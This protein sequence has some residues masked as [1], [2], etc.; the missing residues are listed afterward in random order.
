MHLIKPL[1]SASVLFCLSQPMTTAQIEQGRVEQTEST[2]AKFRLKR[3]VENTIESTPSPAPQVEAS[4]ANGNAQNDNKNWKPGMILTGSLGENALNPTCDLELAKA[5]S[6]EFPDSPEAA[7][8]HAVALTKSSQVEV[9]LKEVRRAR[10]LARATGDPNYFNRAVSE[11]EDSLKADPDNLC[12]RYGLGWAYYMQA[13]LF[14]EEAKKQEKA[15]TQNP[16]QPYKKQSKLNSNLLAGA[17]ILASVITGTK[18]PAS[19]IPH[20]PGALEGTPEWAQGQIKA[21]YK[22]S[23]DML[24][25]VIKR[26]PKDPWAQ[27]YRVHVNEEYDGNNASALAQLGALK[28]KFPNNPAVEFFLADAQ[29]RNGNFAAGASSLGR[30]VQLKLEGK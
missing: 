3:P 4:P 17:G 8:I 11:Y 12:V 25:E 18:P 5:Q 15:K 27:V 9:A 22:K 14:G 6:T 7:F 30:A 24:A 29:A 19:A 2:G 26:D 20:I 10:N 1:I 16:Y 23:L 28:N 13:Y 21:Y